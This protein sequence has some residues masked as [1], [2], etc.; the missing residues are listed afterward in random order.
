MYAV[1]NEQCCCLCCACLDKADVIMNFGQHQ[2]DICDMFCKQYTC[3]LSEA[4]VTCSL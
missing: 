3:N 2:Q 1:G 4:N